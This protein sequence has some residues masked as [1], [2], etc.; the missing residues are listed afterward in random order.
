MIKITTWNLEK[1]EETVI[2]DCIKNHQSSDLEK[3]AKTLN[4]SI[5]TLHR[6]M[7]EYGIIHKKLNVDRAITLLE[8]NG[9]K[10]NKIKGQ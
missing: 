5:R 1:V 10:I 2:R 6:R 3:I 9:Y 7:K 8:K 4:I